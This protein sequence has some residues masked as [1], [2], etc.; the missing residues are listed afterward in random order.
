[1]S[2]RLTFSTFCPTASATKGTPDDTADA[3]PPGRPDARRPREHDPPLG[4]AWT[5]EGGTAAQ[6]RATVP[7]RG[8]RG[9]ARADVQRLSPAARGRRRGRRQARTVDR[10]AARAH[11]VVVPAGASPARA[12]WLTLISCGSAS[13]DP[14]E[15]R[16]YDEQYWARP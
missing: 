1:M 11:P 4:G 10:L 6:W 7:A 2:P 8:R 3:G 15:H 5:A 14:G 16:P 13:M 9:D 12:S